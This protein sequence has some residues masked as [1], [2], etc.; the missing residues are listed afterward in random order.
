MKKHILSAGL[1]AAIA[2]GAPIA[3]QAGDYYNSGAYSR[4]P[5]YQCVNERRGR[6]TTGGILGAVVGGLAGSGVASSKNREEGAVLGAIVGAVAGNAI[7]KSGS[8]CSNVT[9][10]Y[11]NSYGY[12]DDRYDDRYSDNRRYDDDYDRGYRSSSYNDDY[13]DDDNYYDRRAYH[14]SG[15]CKVVYS[16]TRLP[17]GMKVREPATYCQ[18]RDGV[19]TRRN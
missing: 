14:G 18:S 11:S 9:S 19:W 4:D 1:A 8:Q 3:A 5:Y 17:D 13:R 12:N 16:T 7:A 15:N 2:L 10:S 6:G